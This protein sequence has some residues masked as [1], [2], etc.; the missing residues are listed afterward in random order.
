M[1]ARGGHPQ[2]RP[3]HMPPQAARALCSSS[4]RTARATGSGQS[5]GS[6]NQTLCVWSI[7]SLKL[8]KPKTGGGGL[9]PT[10]AG[11]KDGRRPRA[12][13]ALCALQLLLATPATE[14]SAPRPLT[15][16][17]GTARLELLEHARRGLLQVR[18][19]V[20]RRPTTPYPA[21]LTASAAPP[22]RETAKLASKR[23]SRRHKK[24]A[25]DSEG[26]A[27]SSACRRARPPL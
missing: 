1:C 10:R 11:S 23:V 6:R 12:G 7:S 3:A 9:T 26:S 24:G 13:P 2:R 8:S 25:A 15:T 17:W 16:P 27:G 19:D 5:S 14:V 18:Q 4:C 21:T 22:G 20:P